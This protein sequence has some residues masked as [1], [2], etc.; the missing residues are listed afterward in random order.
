MATFTFRI[1]DSM[2]GRLSS[3]EVRSWL[4]L[5]LANSL[6]LPPDPGAGQ[7]R[8]SLTLPDNLVHKAACCVGCSPSTFL[9]RL[10]AANLGPRRAP[11]SPQATHSA[12]PAGMRVPEAAQGVWRPQ[13]SQYRPTPVHDNL[14]P[15][16]T[17]GDAFISVLVQVLIL[18]FV[19]AGALLFGARKSGT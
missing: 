10:A 4:S 15:T 14:A 2:A 7:E 1:P 8:I 5:Y 6:P 13:P 9:R 18:G 19:V 12:K 11:M 3:A 17:A 16:P